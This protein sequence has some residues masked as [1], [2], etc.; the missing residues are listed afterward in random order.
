M[1]GCH[2][3]E[4]CSLSMRDGTEVDL[5]ERVS[6][7]GLGTGDGNYNQDIVFEKRIYFQ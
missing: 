3:L 7:E 4:V 2:V 5:E 6:G 1:F